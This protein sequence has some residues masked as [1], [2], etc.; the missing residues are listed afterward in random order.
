[1][2]FLNSAF[3]VTKGL[4]QFIDPAS[5]WTA[6]GLPLS[7]NEILDKQ[8]SKLLAQTTPTVPVAPGTPNPNDAANA[9]QAQA[10]AL[11]QRRG[12]LATLYAGSTGGG[13]APMTGSR[14]LGT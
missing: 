5:K 2:S 8:N 12:L 11:R 9:A 4:D 14:Q 3:K 7:P 1:M 10:D 6:S 13:G